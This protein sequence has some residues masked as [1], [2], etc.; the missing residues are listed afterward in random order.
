MDKKTV[1]F[2]VLSIASI[3]VYRYYQNAEHYYDRLTQQKYASE[4]VMGDAPWKHRAP[5][6]WVHAQ[7]EYNARDWASWG[8]RTSEQLNQPFLYVTMK[9]VLETCGESFNICLIDDAAFKRLLPDWNVDMA[10]LPSPMK[11]HYRQFGVALLLSQYGGFYV[12][13]S[14]LCRVDLAPIY[15]EAMGTMGC[16][17]VETTQGG[18]VRPDP[19]FL[20]CAKGNPTMKV[21]AEY[22]GHLLKRDYTA[23]KDFLGSLSAWCRQNMAVVDG[24]VVGAKRPDGGPVDI[25]DLLTQNDLAVDNSVVY[26]DAAEILRRP[27][28]AWFSRMSVEQ[29]LE[30]DLT[31]F[32]K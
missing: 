15:K 10:L 9:S 32:K 28:Y 3:Y 18:E 21:F 29:L 19:A 26:L 11:E 5:Y 16:F 12:P 1:V 24:R 20:G 6:L 30:S 7:G 31:L 4:Y 13:C 17:A 22:I 27:K 25:G 23:E 14:T 2:V 8:S